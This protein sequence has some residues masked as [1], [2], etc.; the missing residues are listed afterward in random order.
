MQRTE[1]LIEKI[2]EIIK[3][4]PNRNINRED[5]KHYKRCSA[6]KYQY[7]NNYRSLR[8]AVHRNINRED[9]KIIR[10]VAH[11]KINR[12]DCKNYTRC[13]ALKY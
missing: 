2:L 5:C 4:A 13:S 7:K 1:I 9:C 6:P 3:D 8:G 11:R 10:G 12:E